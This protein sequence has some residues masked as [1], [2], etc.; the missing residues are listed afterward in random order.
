MEIYESLDEIKNRLNEALSFERLSEAERAAWDGLQIAQSKELLDEIEYFKGELAL[1]RGRGF[2]AL[3]HFERA[4]KFNPKHSEAYNDKAITLGELGFEEEAIEC[5]D[6]GIEA[7]PA[8]ANLYHNKG[9]ILS[10]MGKYREAIEWY[11]KA[12]SIEPNSAITYANMAEAFEALEDYEKALSNYKRAFRL[13]GSR[14]KEIK[15]QLLKKFI[16]INEK[17]D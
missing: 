5:F 3:E 4:I 15:K 11:K 9:W 13:L 10:K 14:D 17:L 16:E 8:Y 7:D 12:L 6:K 2:E 1:I